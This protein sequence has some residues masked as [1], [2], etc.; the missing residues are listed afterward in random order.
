MKVLANV[1]SFTPLKLYIMRRAQ[2]QLQKMALASAAAQGK[3]LNQ[4]RR[5]CFPWV[6]G[7][8]TYHASN[9]IDVKMCALLTETLYFRDKNPPTGNG[10]TDRPLRGLVL[11]F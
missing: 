6:P 1:N 9:L 4:I 3:N 7:K 10:L 11:S 2:P 5:S 8:Y